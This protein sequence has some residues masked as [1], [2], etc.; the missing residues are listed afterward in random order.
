MAKE[1]NQNFQFDAVPNFDQIEEEEREMQKRRIATYRPDSLKIGN[2]I[3]KIY[4]QYTGFSEGLE[5]MDR[6]F[7]IAKE[8]D[9]P[10]GLMIMGPPGVGKSSLFHYFCET[11]PRSTLFAPGFGC[12]K[13]RASAR[14]T[15]GQIIA[16]LLK[17][18]KY[19]FL[20]SSEKAAYTRKDQAIELV[21]LKGTRLIFIDEAHNLLRQVIRRKNEIGEPDATVFLSELM[22][23]TKAGLVLG[24][25]DALDKLA[26]VD[27]YLA[28]R[29]SGRVKLACFAA[30]A[31]WVGFLRAF[32]DSSKGFDLQ[33]LH[34]NNQVKLLHTASLG[35]PRQFK[36]L[37]IEAVLIAAQAH[38][39]S[40]S[41]EHFKQA[42]VLVN[43][44]S[45]SRTN[46]YV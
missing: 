25:S 32:A 37:M 46:P 10:Q 27:C 21:K 30:T 34:D 36:K 11:L 8:F 45:S 16:S 24:G 42:F 44:R 15:S 41:P 6:I 2:Q 28:D 7:Q 38:C 12:I 4:V 40:V 26:E 39:K 17:S 5:S 14:P 18:Y 29:I 35:S 9:M 33:I 23:E 20:C 3:S 31:E 13:I 1:L 43:G 19:P 22:D